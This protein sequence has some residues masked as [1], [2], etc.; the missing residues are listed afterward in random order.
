M[1][2]PDTGLAYRG[3]TNQSLVDRFKKWHRKS[4]YIM[5]V[6]ERLYIQIVRILPFFD[7]PSIMHQLTQNRKTWQKMETAIDLSIQER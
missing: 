6:I 4:T 7:R 2:S 5:A 3:Y 1:D